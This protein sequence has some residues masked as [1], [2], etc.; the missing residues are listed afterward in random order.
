MFSSAVGLNYAVR[1]RALKAL[2]VAPPALRAAAGLDLAIRE[3]YCA[4][5][6]GRM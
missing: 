3:P 2:R 1:V 6:D 5:I 4:I